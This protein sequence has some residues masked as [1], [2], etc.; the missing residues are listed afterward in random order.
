MGQT[1]RDAQD[2]PNPSIPQFQVH[3]LP[4]G[5]SPQKQEENIFLHFP[6]HNAFDCKALLRVQVF[7]W[8]PGRVQ[9][10]NPIGFP[11]RGKPSIHLQGNSLGAHSVQLG[12]SMLRGLSKARSC[13]KRLLEPLWEAELCCD[14]GRW[15][16]GRALD[17]PSS[18]H[19]V[20]RGVPGHGI[21]A[22]AS[23]L[24]GC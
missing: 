13:L 3:T 4:D 23:R 9:S 5:L 16:E 7:P 21:A 8:K 22:S 18:L 14:N 12:I 20:N 2:V 6:T 24:L 17:S 10:C 19:S 1:P 11:Q 15:P